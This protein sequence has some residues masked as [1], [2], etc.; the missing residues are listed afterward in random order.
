MET[1]DDLAQK[2]PIMDEFF[3]RLRTEQDMSDAQVE[4]A[5]ESF[6]AHGIT[7]KQL[8]ATGDLS[9]SDEKLEKIGIAQAGLGIAI[10]LVKAINKDLDVSI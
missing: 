10:L 9:L 6:S 2:F 7:F 3:E 8:M 1:E 4:Q 5:K